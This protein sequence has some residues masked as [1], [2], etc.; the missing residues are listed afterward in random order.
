MRKLATLAITA[1]TVLAVATSAFAQADPGDVG[2]YFDP[3]A[4]STTSV[5][6]GFVTF[7]V[8]LIGSEL[9]PISGWE[10]TVTLSDPTWTNL[11]GTLNPPA[12]VNVGSGTNLDILQRR[13]EAHFG[14]LLLSCIR[15]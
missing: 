10:G 2:I 9:G 1:L 12:A 7:P 11:G 14:I 8:Y 13:L 15:L 4:T 6:P 3:A 5:Q